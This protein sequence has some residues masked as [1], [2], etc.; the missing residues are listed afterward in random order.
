MNRTYAKKKTVLDIFIIKK[1]TLKNRAD[2]SF[3][4]LNKNS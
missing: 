1:N 4:K 2:I 3:K